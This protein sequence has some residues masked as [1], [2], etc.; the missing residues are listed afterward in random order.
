MILITC[1][2]CGATGDKSCRK[3]NGHIQ[4][5]K[6]LVRIR[7]HKKAELL[8]GQQVRASYL[9]EWFLTYGHIFKETDT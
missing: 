1:R 3:A 4:P 2:K 7:D 6:H 8:R 5:I 9:A